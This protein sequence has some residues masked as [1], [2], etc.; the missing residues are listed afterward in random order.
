MVCYLTLREGSSCPICQVIKSLGKLVVTG[1]EQ[2]CD[3]VH[4]GLSRGR[5]SEGSQLRHGLRQVPIGEGSDDFGGFAGWCLHLWKAAYALPFLRFKHLATPRRNFWKHCIVY[6]SLFLALREGAAL[7]VLAEV[8]LGAR[9][10]V[11]AEGVS[12]R[13]PEF[14]SRTSAGPY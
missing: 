4:G 5:H 9:I 2:P 3:R 13:A 12:P 1:S 8:A 6:A 14:S 11:T 7:A 10:W